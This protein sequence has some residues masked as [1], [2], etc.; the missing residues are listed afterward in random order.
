MEGD[1]EVQAAQRARGSRH[2][3]LR[4]IW[5]NLEERDSNMSSTGD[6]PV[7]NW[8]G[9]LEVDGGVAIVKRVILFEPGDHI[10]RPRRGPR[11]V[12]WKSRT[13]DHVDGLLVR[14]IDVPDPSHQDIENK[15]V[16]TTPFYTGEIPLSDLRDYREFVAFDDC[17]KISIAA[18]E[19]EP[20]G[21]PRGFMEGRW[22]SES[23]TSGY[24]KGAW[25]GHDGGLVGY[26]RGRYVVKEGDRLLFGKWINRSGDFGGLVRGWWTPLRNDER[27]PAGLFEGRW[28]DEFFRVVGS[29]RGHYFVCEGDT[30][31]FLHGRWSEDC[32]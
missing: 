21:C 4:I 27:G 17:N 30:T 9:S 23:D 15:I 8:S 28:V 5:G 6:C 11:T 10:V 25:M 13:K 20:L 29:F 16:I 24:F 2:Y 18:T 26:F 22:V 14:I 1:P 12:S 31:G 7:S 19:V 32:R 3:A